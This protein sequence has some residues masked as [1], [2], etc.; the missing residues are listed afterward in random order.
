ML[1]IKRFCVLH[2]DTLKGSKFWVL[3]GNGGLRP[4]V[5]MVNHLYFMPVNYRRRAALT[6]FIYN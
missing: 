1:D 2:Q 6:R 4:L 5:H 3:S